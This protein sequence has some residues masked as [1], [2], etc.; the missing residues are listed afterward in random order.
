[1]ADVKEEFSIGNMAPVVGLDGVTPVNKGITGTTID[2]MLSQDEKAINSH[3]SEE[4]HVD[5]DKIMEEFD[6]IDMVVPGAPV[7]EEGDKETNNDQKD[8]DS[9]LQNSMVESNI[10]PSETDKKNE[11]VQFEE[12]TEENLMTESSDIDDDIQGV[13]TSLNDK[14]YKTKYSC[15]GHPSSKV[16]NDV[17]RDGILHGKLYSTARVVFDGKYD[18]DAPTGWT[19]K[20]LNNGKNTAIY[21]DPPVFKITDGIPVKAFS[22]WKAKYM[23]SLKDWVKSLP[24]EGETQ[25]E[26]PEESDVLESAITD[27]LL[28]M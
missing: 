27:L 7:T 12:V 5:V 24:K 3:N 26:K 20:E 6:A 11:T 17:Y 22:K 21:V 28:D 15:S 25:K 14:G 4:E 13:I 9:K 8:T 1:M 10:H 23:E 18:I 16:H 2:E 19:K